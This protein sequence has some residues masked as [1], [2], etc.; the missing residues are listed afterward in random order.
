MSLNEEYDKAVDTVQKLRN[1]LEAQ[2]LAEK[3][4]E[5][6]KRFEDKYFR[7]KNSSGPD[8]KWPV[9]SF[10]EKVT[11]LNDAIIHSFETA[12]DSCRFTIDHGFHFL[13]QKQIPKSEW[14][15]ALRRF[16]AQVERLG[17]R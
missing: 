10:C 8:R 16:K 15:S 17:K 12:P 6:R 13:F 1:K 4:P 3:L 11:G 5:L 14:S 9:Y 7:Y 2:K